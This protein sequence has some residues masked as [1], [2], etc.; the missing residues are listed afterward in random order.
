MGAHSGGGC[1]GSGYYPSPRHSC[2]EMEGWGT[3]RSALNSVACDKLAGWLVRPEPL[4]SRA[5][6]SCSFDH[7]AAGWCPT[8]GACCQRGLVSWSCSKFAL[9]AVLL[10]S[11]AALLVATCHYS[12]TG[13]PAAG[14]A[15]PWPW[16]CAWQARLAAAHRSVDGLWGMNWRPGAGYPAVDCTGRCRFPFD[17]SSLVACSCDRPGPKTTPSWSFAQQWKD[18]T[19]RGGLDPGPSWSPRWYLS[20]H[21]GLRRTL[22]VDPVVKWKGAE[23]LLVFAGAPLNLVE[24]EM[25]WTRRCVEILV[26]R[27]ATKPLSSPQ[28]SLYHCRWIFSAAW[29]L[30]PWSL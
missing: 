26:I 29:L 20:F 2:A 19:W 11:S 27:P 14:A 23:M 7:L 15:A 18:A 9:A 28:G 3:C 21:W 4:G 16:S 12:S 30:P 1:C 13:M 5:A 24:V 6:W 17:S 25:W 22:P 10:A 8:F